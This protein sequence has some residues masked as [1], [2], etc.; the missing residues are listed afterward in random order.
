[1]SGDDGLDAAFLGGRERQRGDRDFAA[2]NR[3]DTPMGFG[4]PNQGAEA[5]AALRARGP[6]GVLVCGRSPPAPVR[7]P[8][9]SERRLSSLVRP[10]PPTAQP[11]ASTPRPGPTWRPRPFLTAALQGPCTAA[12][13]LVRQAR[14]A[15]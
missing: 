2:A 15:L 5:P 13:E 6:R 14:R 12:A 1:R 7:P 4:P 8:P 10:P 11:R 9:D 3:G